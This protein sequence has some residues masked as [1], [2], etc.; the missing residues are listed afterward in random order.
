MNNPLLKKIL[1]HAIAI[2]L[3]LI[4]SL[5]FC[6]PAL[7]GNVLDQHDIIGWKGMAQ[8]SFEYKEKTGHYPL[9]NPNLFSGMPNYQVMM[10]GKTVL[11]N[12]LKILSLGLPKPVNFFFLA[13]V[14]FYIL[15]LALRIKPVIGMLAG[16]AYS[17]STYNPV[18][19]AAGHDTQMLAT[20][21]M[22]LLLAG[23]I[24]IYEKKYWLGFALTTFAAYQQI[25]VNHL[26]VTYY[27]FLIAVLITIGYL[28]KWI[29]E[30]DWKHILIAG[31]IAVVSAIIGVAGNA[32]ILKTT[33]EYSKFTMR[34]GK[35]IEV[36]GDS[37]KVAKTTG[38]D[39]GY[40]F[41]YSLGKAES[42]TLIMPNAFGGTSKK[43]IDETSKV[44][45]K[46]TDKGVPESNA[47]QIA[48]SI[49]GGGYWG[50]LYTSGPA[51][52]GVLIC[53]FGLIGFVI[54]KGPLRWGLLAAT[55]LG[56]FMSWGKYF[57]EFN[58]FLFEHLPLYNKFRSPPFA[59]VIP[60]V[61][62]GIMAAIALQQ[63]L[64]NEK[65]RELLAK[66]FKKIL[67][68]AG[69]LFGLLALMYLSMSYSTSA[70]KQIIAAYTDP[71]N[72]SDEMGRLIVSG[73][74]A[75]RRAMFGG[76]LLRALGIAILGLGTV[77][78]FAKN[79]I[80]ALV[81][82]IILLVVSTLDVTIV[83]KAYLNDESYISA[84]EYNSENFSPNAIEQEILKDKDPNFRVFN[85]AGTS[86][87][88]TFSES[89]TSYFLKSIGGYHPAKLR[90]Y[91]D[92][93]EKYLLGRPNPAVL[94]ML[95]AKY[96]VVQDPQNGQPGLIKNPDVYGNCW[97][98]K[99]VRTVENRVEAIKALGTTNLRDTAVIEMSLIPNL[100]QPQWDSSSYIRMTKFDNDAMEY[101]ANCNGPQFAVFSEVYYPKGWN[102]YLDGKKTDYYNVN[103]I[104][105]GMPLPAGKHSI[106]FI[107][108][109]ASV[110]QGRS[111]MFISSILIGLILI[112]GLFMAWKTSGT[113]A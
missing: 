91:Q 94:N 64:F 15:C 108:E 77:W 79:K 1:P 111:I 96:I 31:S 14:F 17:F 61:T 4:V 69:G 53:L 65:S 101:E 74:K 18:I 35:D 102:A 33:S 24:S 86:T 49:P 47:I 88:S 107:F 76:Q 50:E 89:R 98:V 39:T 9:W 57:G 34:G 63:L 90:I 10:E 42:A 82:A 5:I 29:K 112:G 93:I 103:Y 43:P 72:G 113:K 92:I 105:R 6:K 80:S 27:L 83:S 23:L 48:Q 2:I 21:L 40:A 84:D 26:Q 67:Y 16:L 71:N 7:E 20:G 52:L 62:V 22:P 100:S 66:D 78:L 104:L 45:K 46:L 85:M 12:M 11:P 58:T 87:G 99:N 36:N 70:D 95:N 3:F 13:C 37:V 54:A 68:A 25:G 55:L 97:L 81:A 32:L 106:K 19:V 110:K 8:N 51:Y 41:E 56:I 44:V 59:Q 38:L 73:L 60:Q 75:D 109:P 28:V 30:K